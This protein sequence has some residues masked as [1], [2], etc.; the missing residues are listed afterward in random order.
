[1]GKVWPKN[2]LCQHMILFCHNYVISL[3]LRPSLSLFQQRWYLRE[4]SKLFN[5]SYLLYS[6]TCC[7]FGDSEYVVNRVW[8]PTGCQGLLGTAYH[9]CS[10]GLYSAT[11]SSVCAAAQAAKLNTSEQTSLK[12]KIK[13]TS[14]VFSSKNSNLVLQSQLQGHNQS[15]TFL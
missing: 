9:E 13:L 6:V 7:T 15:I 10:R 8:C 1:M 14:A 2:T 12:H 3:F 5:I 4:Y 11:N